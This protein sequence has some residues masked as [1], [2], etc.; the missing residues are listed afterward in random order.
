[1]NAAGDR[2]EAGVAEQTV[3]LFGKE[4]GVAACIALGQSFLDELVSSR[5]V[6]EKGDGSRFFSDMGDASAE[7]ETG[8][9]DEKESRPEVIE[10][11]RLPHNG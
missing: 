2:A 8:R 5:Y 3:P 4:E 10:L 9:P 1:V 11:Q 6:I 7:H